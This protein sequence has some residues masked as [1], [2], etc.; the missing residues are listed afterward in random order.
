MTRQTVS[1]SIES[2]HTEGVNVTRSFSLHLRAINLSPKT[3]ETYLDAVRQFLA[4]LKDRELASSTANNRY[5]GLQSF[6][7]WLLEEGDIKRS[8]LER[9]KPPKIID[10]PPA[11]LK[12]DQLTRL[13]ASC[14]KANWFESRRDTSLLRVFIDTGARLSE[15]VGLNMDDL[16]LDLGALHVLGKGRRPRIPSIS[17]RTSRALDRYLRYRTNHRE[18][19]SLAVWLGRGGGQR[20]GAAMTTSG[21]R[22]VIWRRAVGA[23]LVRVHPHML[24]HSWARDWTAKGNEGDLMQLAGWRCRTM[25]SRY[26]ASAATERAREAHKRISL[27]D[28]L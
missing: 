28:R 5:R 1:P 13:V 9:M 8:P 16:D 19:H 12:E 20:Q 10:N 26:A 17:K 2:P 23:G 21:V 14:E 6:S 15:V 3:Q 11:V 25:L 7:N 18:A 22:Q 4:F 27:G 24:R